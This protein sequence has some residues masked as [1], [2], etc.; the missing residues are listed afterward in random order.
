MPIVS[1]KP[2]GKLDLASTHENHLHMRAYIF[3]HFVA[4]VCRCTYVCRVVNFIHQYAESA[5]VM[6][7]GPIVRVRVRG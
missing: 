1:G 6:L 2:R 7:L 4:V 3:M 5:I